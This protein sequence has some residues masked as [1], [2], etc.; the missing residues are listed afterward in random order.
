MYEA[1]VQSYPE[2]TRPVRPRKAKMLAFLL[3][4]FGVL[5]FLLSIVLLG[6]VTDSHGM[7]VPAVVYVLVYAQFVL[8]AT[9]AVC[10][11]FIWQGRSWARSVA[12]GLSVI[13]LLGAVVNLFTG[14]IFPAITAF[15]VNAALIRLLNDDEVKE[16]CGN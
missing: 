16:W 13:N 6:T 10:G 12:I 9:Q 7:R 4:G 8:S 5:G 15:A 1:D 2:P 3:G 14:A 11:V